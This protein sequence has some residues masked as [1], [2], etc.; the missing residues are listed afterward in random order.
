MKKLDKIRDSI[1]LDFYDGEIEN[2]EIVKLVQLCDELLQAKTIPS[3]AKNNPITFNG[4]YKCRKDKI[5]TFGGK[6]FIPDNE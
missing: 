1:E 3:Y 2:N 6:K 5:F 4:V